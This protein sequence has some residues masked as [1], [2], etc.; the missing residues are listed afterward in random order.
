MSKRHRPVPE[1]ERIPPETHKN[2]SASLTA[3]MPG[4]K[5]AVIAFSHETTDL[6]MVPW[7]WVKKACIGLGISRTQFVKA[8][9]GKVLRTMT[10]EGKGIN[11][12]SPLFLELFLK[13]IALEA[14]YFFARAHVEHFLKHTSPDHKGGWDK[15]EF[16]DDGTKKTTMESEHSTA[17]KTSWA[18]ENIEM[19]EKP[20]PEKTAKETPE[21]YAHYMFMN[22][23]KTW[24]EIAS[25][26]F[27]E[28]ARDVEAGK[29]IKRRSFADKARRLAIKYAKGNNLPTPA[30]GK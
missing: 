6:V 7:G 21:A 16:Q 5:G 28:Q 3:T 10:V 25:N 4:I 17:D 29:G 14:K 9:S 2:I 20:K 13:E 24:F 11:P 19:P 22:E 12:P 26:I 18:K 15:E 1:S 23:G 8:I 30:Q 27:P